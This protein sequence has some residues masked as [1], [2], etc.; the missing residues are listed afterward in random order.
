MRTLI[1]FSAT[2]IGSIPL[3]AQSSAVAPP[4]LAIATD[5]AS[6]GLR[7]I[8]G[9]PGAA[10]VG[11][12]AAMET[13]IRDAQVSS[14]QS[15]ALVRSADDNRLAIVRWM[16]AGVESGALGAAAVDRYALSP[17]GHSAAIYSE[18]NGSVIVFSGLPQAPRLRLRLNSSFPNLISLAVSDDG[19]LAVATVSGE[20]GQSL[21]AIA[22]G[23]D[24]IRLALP[25][26]VTAF[27]F[28]PS[29]HDG[30][31]ATADALV[32]IALIDSDPAYM[33]WP[34]PETLLSGVIGLR[35]D[36]NQAFVMSSTGTGTV[37]DTTNGRYATASCSCS[38][39]GF[40]PTALRSV[41]HVGDTREGR[42][43]LFD[44]SASDPK[45]WFVPAPSAGM[46]TQQ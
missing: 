1:L 33:Q 31:A 3:I 5:P 36:S 28:R 11:A 20:G 14:D 30:V 27:A 10:I 7:G 21:W 25:G 35:A 39:D 17:A 13:A 41:F 46:E 38:P 26:S 34:L 4:R 43:W 24:P 12:P 37:V 8:F 6:G 45:M 22:S 19:A 42:S 16:A 32:A 40:W 23:A 44:A 18:E 2:V 29:T 15:F 9:I